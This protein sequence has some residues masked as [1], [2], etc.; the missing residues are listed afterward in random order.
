M[1]TVDDVL[2]PPVTATDCSKAVILVWFLL[3]VD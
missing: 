2:K 1:R 3:Y